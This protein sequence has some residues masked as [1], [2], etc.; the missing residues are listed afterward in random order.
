MPLIKKLSTKKIFFLILIT[1]LLGSFWFSSKTI[2]GAA[3]P[4]SPGS[5]A[6]C[7]EKI[8]IS[9]TAKPPPPP[10]PPEERL[11]VKYPSIQ[12][13]RPI[14]EGEDALPIFIRYIFTFAIAIAG[15]IAFAVLVFAGFRYLASA[16]NPTAMRDARESITAA[17][18]G[19][20]LLLG[21]VLLLITINPQLTRLT[22][23]SIED[24]L[25]E[26]RGTLAGVYLISDEEKEIELE[27]KILRVF[28]NVPTTG[29]I[30]DLAL[31]TYNFDN[32]TQKICFQTDWRNDIQFNAVLHTERDF[33]GKCRIFY[34]KEFSH[35][36]IFGGV[37]DNVKGDVSSVTIFSK[38]VLF[39]KEPA[40][41]F[42]VK[43]YK[44]PTFDD[45]EGVCTITGE[46]VEPKDIDKC[47]GDN[48][49]DNVH[50]L[51]VGEGWVL[52]VFEEDDG[53]GKCQ[54]FGSG[55]AK[56]I[57]EIRTH[58]IGRCKVGT[59]SGLPIIGG[60]F[61]EW[62]PCISSFAIFKGRIR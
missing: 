37:G 60:F 56:E 21:S 16:G 45:E 14:A 9:E 11:E 18:L 6:T 25:L 43:F 59:G 31:Q 15:L 24:F 23:E 35:D 12:G 38:S 49:N 52:A 2:L 54:I 48:W 50:S 29:S 46:Q 61:G 34:E 8:V 58:Y 3:I 5:A 40:G 36:L 62:K 7:E 17:L 20:I 53:T 4:P 44:L 19:L 27:D 57:S 41:D 28:K 30:S 32:Q 26:A 22:L 47:P 1:V 13:I 42:A 55:R 39:P 51:K 10:V 33:K